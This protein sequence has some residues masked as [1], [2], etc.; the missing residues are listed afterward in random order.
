MLQIEIICSGNEN[1][2]VEET[3]YFLSKID[4][5]LVREIRY[6]SFFDEKNSA[7]FFRC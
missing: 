4:E 7:P 5:C 6:S 2:L 3:N 1:D